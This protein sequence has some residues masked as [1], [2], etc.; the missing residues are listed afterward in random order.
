MR[1]CSSNFRDVFVGR[2]ENIIQNSITDF[3]DKEEEIEETK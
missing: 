2:I 3:E 1:L